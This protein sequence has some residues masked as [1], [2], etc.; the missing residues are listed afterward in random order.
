MRVERDSGA[1]AVLRPTRTRG[2]CPRAVCLK[3]SGA[4]RDEED[5][6]SASCAEVFNGTHAHRPRFS[7][8]LRVSPL[9]SPVVASSASDRP[10]RPRR[11]HRP[12]TPSAPSERLTLLLLLLRRGA[13]GGRPP[14]DVRPPSTTP[15]P[16]A[17]SASV[18]NEPTR[19]P[20]IPGPAADEGADEGADV[21]AEEG[22]SPSRWSTGAENPSPSSSYNDRSH[23]PQCAR[24]RWDRVRRRREPVGR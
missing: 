13:V 24:T 11:P 22:V 7:L 19:E 8:T 15:G 21:D 1:T 9:L 5:G 16:A 17:V 2:E 3:R 20:R 18:R 4:R 10:R 12:P 6:E 23:P 14:A